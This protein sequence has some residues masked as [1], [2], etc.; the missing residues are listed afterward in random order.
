MKK[1]QEQQHQ[2]SLQ[3]NKHRNEA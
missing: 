1:S 2:H 3:E